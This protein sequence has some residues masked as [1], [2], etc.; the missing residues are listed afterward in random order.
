MTKINDDT[1]ENLEAPTLGRGAS[2]AFARG[3]SLG[4]NYDREEHCGNRLET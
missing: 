4:W 2:L 1:V 3:A